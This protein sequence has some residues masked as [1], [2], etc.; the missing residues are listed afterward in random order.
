MTKNEFLQQLLPRLTGLPATEQQRIL[1]YYNELVLDGVESGR[2]EETIVAGFGS[3]EDAARKIWEDY[4]APPVKVRSVG[5][6]VLIG[7]AWFFGA[8]VGFP[9]VMAAGVL[10]LCGWIILLSLAITAVSLLFSGVASCALMVTILGKAPQ[11]A[12]FQFGAGV[13]IIGL[14]I[15]SS[16]GV[17]KLFRLYWAFSRGLS[18]FISRAFARKGVRYAS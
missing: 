4:A 1:D 6:R 3:V 16:V 12:L 2:D 5:M 14:G 7:V 11:A 17:Y 13:L 9:L 10:Y 18:A 8:I 15:L